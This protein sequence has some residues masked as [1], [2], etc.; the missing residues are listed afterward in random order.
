MVVDESSNCSIQFISRQH[1]QAAPVF[2]GKPI[3]IALGTKLQ[4]ARSDRLANG[5]LP[6]RCSPALF[7]RMVGIT[8]GSVLEVIGGE[9][10]AGGWREITRQ[11]WPELLWKSE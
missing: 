8:I 6:R 3:F 2:K 1:A 7:C 5:A 4:A 10:G 9:R 11:T